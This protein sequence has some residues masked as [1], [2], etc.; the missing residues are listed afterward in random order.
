MEV[1]GATELPGEANPLSE[2][3]LIHILK[4]AASSSQQQIQTS[5]KQLQTWETQ[6]HFYVYLQSAF[7]DRRLPLEVRYIAITQLKL[8][9]D[10]YWR[11]TAVNAVPKEDK[12]AIR[13]RLLESGVNEADGRL[14]LQNALVI[15]KVVRYEFPNTWPDVI[16]Q[17]IRLLRTSAEPEANPLHLPRG[18]LIALHIVKEL[19]TGRLRSTKASLQSAAPLLLQVIGAIYVRKTGEAVA[20]IKSNDAEE[21]FLQ[22]TLDQ[23][24]LA[25][26]VARRLITAGY[27]FPNR[28]PEVQE[29]A[30]I[31]DEQFQGFLNLLY[32]SGRALPDGIA[33]L[34]E[35]H[36]LQFAK[37]HVELA[38]M[39]P[40]AFVLL[41][42]PQRIAQYWQLIAQFGQAFGSKPAEFGHIGTDGDAEEER[43]ALEKISLKGLLVLRA[44]LKLIFNPQQ[45]LKFSKDAKRD[46]EK[47]LAI[48]I[49]KGDVFTD[50]F[51]RQIMEVIVRQY[52]VFRSSDLREWEEEPDEWEK[53][54][55]AEG[56]DFET[57]IRPCSEKLFLDL[58]IHY[59]MIVIQ[60][61]MTV[62][63]AIA[64]MFQPYCPCLCSK[65]TVGSA[66]ER[67]HSTKGFHVHSHWPCRC[68]RTR[69]PGFRFLHRQHI[70]IRSAK[71]ETRLQDSAPS[72]SDSHW[73]VDIRQNISR[74]E[75]ISL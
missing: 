50:D 67:R 70:G 46:E 39:H 56:E 22:Q 32:F 44:C 66:G 61:L 11:K 40:V 5:T 69:A 23:T 24:L 27:E 18:L 7:I 25:I 53:R 59:R 28:D 58:T 64:S 71:T 1:E 31:V 37:L 51:A 14:A 16:H 63:N 30:E 3:I 49:L 6:K 29:F 10:K 54:E 65:L 2:S 62:F 17:I 52:F 26:K 48:Q 41:R 19:S 60:P 73:A 45:T 13:S 68:S 33:R 34:L 20:G 74:E 55:E 12:E 47:N 42:G 21:F 57:S 15:A 72:C 4:G 43:H 38:Q 35:K 8:G 75:T 9:I 36:L